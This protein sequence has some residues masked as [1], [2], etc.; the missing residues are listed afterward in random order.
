M[1]VYELGEGEPEFA[2]VAC[3]H[4]DEP[5]GKRA[6]ERFLSEEHELRKPVK[7]VVA[8]E[9]ALQK[10][11]RY[12]DEDLNRAYP[13]DSDS[14]SHESRLA[15]KMLSEIKG[16]KVLDIHSTHSEPVPFAT[17]SRMNDTVM[18][19]LRSTGVERACQ[20]PDNN[21]DLSFQVDCA[22]VECGGQGT[23]EASEMAYD[24]MV[25]FLAAQGIIDQIFELSDPEIFRYT[26]DVKGGD[27][28]FT[29]KN[30]QLVQEGESFAYKGSTKLV[31]T[32]DFY[33][34]LMSTDGYENMLG[35]K[36]EK[37]GRSSE[38]V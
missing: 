25:N 38:L 10:E 24:V 8:N 9:K 15:A 27:W 11:V 37:L 31:T 14:E 17:F 26:E 16:M 34:V 7:I 30:F 4:G 5:C 33:P 28:K 35:H 12:V 29:C 13:G 19:L 20:Y 2:V 18:E 32:E 36:A 21:G 22:L 1:K 3:Q 6:V 23:E